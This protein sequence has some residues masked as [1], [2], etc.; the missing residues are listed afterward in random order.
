MTF[1]DAFV[2]ELSKIAKEKKEEGFISSILRRVVPGASQRSIKR[3]L[4]RN[5][6]MSQGKIKGAWAP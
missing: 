4:L 3:A 2:D 6:I 5:V 1:F